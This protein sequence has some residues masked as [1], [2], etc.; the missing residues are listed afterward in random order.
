MALTGLLAG[1][2]WERRTVASGHISW[3]VEQ[4]TARG[5]LLGYTPK[6]R[7][8]P[9]IQWVEHYFSIHKFVAFH[10]SWRIYDAFFPREVVASASQPGKPPPETRRSPLHP[11]YRN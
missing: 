1:Q 2:E 9:L 8:D 6:N 10:R 3:L 7:N 4:I 5:I 11:Y